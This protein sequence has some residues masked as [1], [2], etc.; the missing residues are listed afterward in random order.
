MVPI[1]YP[2][3]VRGM[4]GA[5]VAFRRIGAIVSPGGMLKAAAHALSQLLMDLLPV[6]IVG[7]LCALWLAR[8]VRINDR[9]AEAS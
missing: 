5:A 4:G 8:E 2:T 6:V 7:S 1:N 9:P 3:R